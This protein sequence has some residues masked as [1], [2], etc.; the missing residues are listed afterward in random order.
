MPNNDDW[1]AEPTL[2]TPGT[3]TQLLRC[4]VGPL[5]PM[6]AITDDLQ[7]RNMHFWKGRSFPHLKTKCPACDSQNIAVWKGY[8]GVWIPTS[9]LTAILEFTAPCLDAIKAYRAA[10]GTLRTATISLTRAGKRPNGAL[11]MTVTTSQWG[12]DQLP[13]PPDLKAQLLKIWDGHNQTKSYT[14]SN[15][16]DYAEPPSTV[17]EVLARRN[18]AA[19]LGPHAT[20]SKHTIPIAEAAKLVADCFTIKPDTKNG[21]DKPA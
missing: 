12:S 17:P 9:R 8:L 16:R 5:P 11:S 1:D 21:K 7:G 20:N 4:G 13:E 19:A 3:R 6:I 18:Q 14:E 10:H 15:P 2:V